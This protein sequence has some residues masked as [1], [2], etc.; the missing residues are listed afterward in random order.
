MDP[1]SM[2]GKELGKLN[3]YRISSSDDILNSLD[4]R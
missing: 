3:H 1:R 2:I 4:S